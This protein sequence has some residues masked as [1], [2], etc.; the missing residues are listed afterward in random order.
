MYIIMD[1]WKHLYNT[2]SSSSS[3]SSS[4]ESVT[5]SDSAPLSSTYSSSDKLTYSDAANITLISFC[6]WSIA[7]WQGQALGVLVG[8]S[9]TG[10]GIEMHF[11]YP[12]LKYPIPHVIVDSTKIGRH[13]PYLSVT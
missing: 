1:W 13:P 7:P 9:G 11:P 3:S 8:R 10:V 6:N 12:S 2:V 4:P 5:V